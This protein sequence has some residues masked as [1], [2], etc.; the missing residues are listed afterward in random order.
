MPEQPLLHYQSAIFETKNA[1][2]QSLLPMAKRHEA[3]QMKNLVLIVG[4]VVLHVVLFI[5]VSSAV[6]WCGILSNGNF[7]ALTGEY[8]AQLGAFYDARKL[9]RTEDL[10]RLAEY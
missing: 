3:F 9:L 5:S 1:G 4:I 10:K 7:D 2:S 8:S 6:G